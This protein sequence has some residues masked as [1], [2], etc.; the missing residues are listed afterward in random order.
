L[1][2]RELT[3][4][5]RARH[6]KQGRRQQWIFLTN[7]RDTTGRPKD[8]KRRYAD[9]VAMNL[10]P[11]KGLTLHGFEIK[12]SRSDFLSE[13]RDPGKSN[14]IKRYCDYW[15]L[16]IPS[17]DVIELGGVPDD[18]G[19]LCADNGSLKVI[20]RAPRLTPEPLSRGIVASLLR[21]ASKGS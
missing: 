15:W 14:E 13:L 17:E 19:V 16:V 21:N 4:L 10:W 20:K 2:T 6:A 5:L 3:S 8:R 7:V 11:S 12:V 9:A 1:K 18:W